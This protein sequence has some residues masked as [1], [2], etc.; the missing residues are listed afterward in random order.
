MYEYKLFVS[1]DQK[2]PSK[3]YN[4][5]SLLGNLLSGLS[6][7]MAWITK[8]SKLTAQM[9]RFALKNERALRN[10]SISVKHT[11]EMS[12]QCKISPMAVVWLYQY[13]FDFVMHIS[14]YSECLHQKLPAKIRQGKIKGSMFIDSYTENDYLHWLSSDNVLRIQPFSDITRIHFKRLPAACKYNSCLAKTLYVDENC[15]LGLCPYHHSDI[16]L[17]SIEE[18]SSFEQ[19]FET[20]SCIDAL[21]KQ[22]QRRNNCKANCSQFSLCKGGCLFESDCVMQD[23]MKMTNEAETL[24]LYSTLTNPA[25]NIYDENMSVLA[26]KFRV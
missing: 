5:I 20:D 1:L 24:G 17:K 26:K 25:G 6:V 3:L 23:F 2:T 11:V 14:N 21:Y 18:V 19:I 7:H 16:Q 12:K 13:G 22:I 15:V 10:R 4:D 9:V 8:Q